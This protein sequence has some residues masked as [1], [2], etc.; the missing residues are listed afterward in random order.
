M[1]T[2]S[3]SGGFDPVHV[4]HVRLLQAASE[5]GRVTVIMNNDHWLQKKKGYVFMPQDERA[6]VLEAIRFVDRVIVSF[7]GEDPEDM[8]VCAELESVKPDLFGNG[9]DRT[10]ENTPESVLCKKLGIE[11]VYGLGGGKMQSSSWLINKSR[12]S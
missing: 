7:H 12:G 1:K 4:G 6:E 11:L 9:G 8:S 2:I 5:Y 10:A 3:V